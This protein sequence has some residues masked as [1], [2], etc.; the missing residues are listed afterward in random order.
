MRVIHLTRT[1]AA[2][3]VGGLEYHIAYLTEALRSRGHEVDV[4]HTKAPWG[5]AEPDRSERS[6]PALKLRMGSRL[7]AIMDIGRKVADRLVHNLSAF[8]VARQVNKL[9]PDIVHQHNY[10]NGM[11]TSLLLSR[12]YPVV[13]TNHTGAYLYLDRW[14]YTRGFQ[15]KLMGLF[16]AVIAPSRELL[17]A[18][19]NSHYIPNGADTSVFYPV[20]P[21]QKRR[22]REKWNCGDKLVFLCPR[23]WAPTKG[24]I[25]LAKAIAHLSPEVRKRC[26]FLFAG[27]ETPGYEQYQQ[28]VTNALRSIDLCEIRVLGN[29]PHTEL[30]EL[31]NA[32]DICVI[33]SI[34]E[35]TSLACLE[36]MACGIVVL[37][38]ATGGL[39]ELIRDGK[40]G[41]LVPPGDVCALCDAME[42]IAVASPEEIEPMR[43][44]ALALVRNEYTWDIIAERT[45]GI[46]KLALQQCG[47]AQMLLAP[48]ARPCDE[49]LAAGTT[50]R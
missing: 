29:L 48:P 19:A 8:A 44:A 15:R 13:F 10:L 40:N 2:E 1:T 23:R 21:E 47:H 39:T 22:L 49:K 17:P 16:T 27:N 9:R 12:K 5:S 31:M 11:L 14:K 24:I 28:S 34:M 32:S 30:A 50:A 46:Y 33:P 25:H 35:A 3:T 37:G 42:K 18:T 36:A 45:E 43:T 38:T 41:W 4:V 20:S 7:P 26:L 6:R